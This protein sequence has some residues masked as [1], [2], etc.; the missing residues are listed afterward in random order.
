MK[1]ILT[2]LL[3]LLLLTCAV[4]TICA[5]SIDPNIVINYDEPNNEYT[6]TIPDDSYYAILKPSI[7]VNTT[8]ANAKVT[9][10]GVEVAST[11]LDGAVTFKITNGNVTYIIEEIEVPSNPS[12]PVYKPPKTGIN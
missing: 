6:V 8:F 9:L 1:K 2:A 4:V 10:N 5:D 7:T 3:S 12:N 11:I